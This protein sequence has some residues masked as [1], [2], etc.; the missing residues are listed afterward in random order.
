MDYSIETFNLK[1]EFSV[2]RGH[3]DIFTH[4][5]RKK[6]ISALR[7]VNL[8]VRKG[9]LLRLVGS[10]G[11]GKPLYGNLSDSLVRLSFLPIPL[12]WHPCAL[13]FHKAPGLRL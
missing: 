9:E 6:E 11:A 13:S 7:N 8:G 4:P 2:F 3:L 5:F 10:N 12:F 1:K